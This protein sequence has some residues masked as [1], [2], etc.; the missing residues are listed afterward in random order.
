MDKMGSS[1]FIR[2]PATPRNKRFKQGKYS[3]SHVNV[4]DSNT[5]SYDEWA[6]SIRMNFEKEFY[7]DSKQTYR[8]YIYYSESPHDKEKYIYDEEQIRPNMFIAIASA[9]RFVKEHVLKCMK[10]TEEYLVV[11]N[12]VG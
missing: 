12:C 5:L 11:P 2:I 8:D 1:E 3:H 10:V 9:P 4:D 6:T 7:I